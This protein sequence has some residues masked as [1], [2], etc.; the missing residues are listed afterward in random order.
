VERE[1]RAGTSIPSTT[2]TTTTTI[3][4]LLPPVVVV[5]LLLL[6]CPLVCIPPIHPH[7]EADQSRPVRGRTAAGARPLFLCSFS[8]S[9]AI[10]RQAWSAGPALSL[11]L[12]IGLI[13]GGRAGGCRCV[14]QTTTLTLGLLAALLMREG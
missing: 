10:P 1:G 13:A 5:V 6:L 14:V 12:A 4:P 3:P 2:T 11:L 7:P 8:T 9:S